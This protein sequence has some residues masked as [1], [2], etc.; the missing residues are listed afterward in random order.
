MGLLR[1]PVLL[2]GTFL[3][4][5]TRTCPLTCM[6][7]ILKKPLITNDQAPSYLKELIALCYSNGCLRSQNAALLVV[8]R[9][10]KRCSESGRHAL[11][12]CLCFWWPRLLGICWHV[13]PSVFNFEN[14]SAQCFVFLV[15]FWVPSSIASLCIQDLPLLYI[16]IYI[17]DG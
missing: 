4:L 2:W 14:L 15:G 7:I 3:S 13:M 16:L 6:E 8:P 5:L 12:P 1:S 17:S 11:T 10:T 9:V